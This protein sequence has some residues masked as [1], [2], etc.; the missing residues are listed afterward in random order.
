MRILREIALG[1]LFDD[2][3]V[4]F[5]DFLQRLG[6]E[7]GVELGLLLL[8]LGVEDF[9]KSGLRNLQHDVPEHLNQAAVGIRRETWV[10]AALGESFHASVVQAKI[11]NRVHHSR[12]GE[13]GAGTHADQQ[14]ILALSEL[15]ALQL[16]QTRQRFF[17]LAID[18]G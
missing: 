13:L 6:V 9:V 7:I 4:L 5:N 2:F 1:L 3:L 8:L 14:R 10:V 11:E 15:L 18:F 16:L 17:H 12:H